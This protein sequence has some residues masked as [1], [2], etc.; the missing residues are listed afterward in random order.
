MSG[1]LLLVTGQAL[2]MSFK[3]RNA[4]RGGLIKIDWVVYSLLFPY[5]FSLNKMLMP[6]F[7]GM[8]RYQLGARFYNIY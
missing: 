6:F 8:L 1:F 3:G 7:A 4:S 5:I 2:L